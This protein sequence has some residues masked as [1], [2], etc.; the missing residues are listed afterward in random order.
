MALIRAFRASDVVQCE[1]I[2]R[3]L[4]EWFGIEES[5]V[6]YLEEL[7]ATECFVAENEGALTGFLSL[8]HHNPFSS[9][10]HVIAVLAGNHGRGIGR[11]LVERAETELRARSVEYL[12]VKTLGPSRPDAS[13]ERTR[14]FYERMGFRPLEENLL[15]GPVNPC[16]I[17][18]K[19]VPCDSGR[20]GER[21][22]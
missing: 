2:L 17:M 19:H 12:Q 3:S 18:V 5:L 15:W 1:R 9:E 16:L 6:R 7:P 4:P 22:S 10:I 8:R 13:Y 20:A 11:A 21:R 14:G